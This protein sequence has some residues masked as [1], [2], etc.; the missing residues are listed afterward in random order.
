MSVLNSA[1]PP[2]VDMTSITH[3]IKARNVTVHERDSDLVFLTVH[4]K[5]KML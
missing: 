3:E 2:S 1:S 5:S 4:L